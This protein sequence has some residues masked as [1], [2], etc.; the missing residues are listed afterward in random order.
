VAVHDVPRPEEPNR[1]QQGEAMTSMR[2][3][4]KAVQV[5]IRRNNS[6]NW[7][8]DKFVRAV[9]TATSKMSKAMQQAY[10]KSRAEHDHIG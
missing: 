8:F 2:K 5:S 1:F 6:W 9:V 7:S 10:A 4:R 3:R